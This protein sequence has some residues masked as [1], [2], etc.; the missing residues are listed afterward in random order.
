M[1]EKVYVQIVATNDE[2]DTVVQGLID[3][4]WGAFDIESDGG[5]SYEHNDS[6]II[7]VLRVDDSDA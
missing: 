6:D 7:L 4:G 5:V 1:N 2:A 3:S